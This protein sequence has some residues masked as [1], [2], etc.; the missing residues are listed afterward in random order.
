[1]MLSLL[2]VLLDWLTSYKRLF[3][4]V[5]IVK[6]YYSETVGEHSSGKERIISGT[7]ADISSFRLAVDLVV[8]TRAVLSHL[9]HSFLHIL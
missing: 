5:S 6:P 8:T 4:P 1:M 2:I 9:F 3:F 7:G